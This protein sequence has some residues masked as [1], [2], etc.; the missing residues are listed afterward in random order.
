MKAAIGR[1]LTIAGVA[2]C[3]LTG[4]WDRIE[5]NQ[6]A[7]VGL[8]GSDSN[9]KTHEQSIYYQI[10]NPGSF[11]L[12]GGESS[13]S[14]VYTYKIVGQTKG[15]LGFKSADILPRKLFT[16]QYQAHIIPESYARQGLTAFLNFYERQFNRRS[17]LNLFVTDSA[18]ADVMTTYTPLER[19]PGRALR[20]LVYNAYL[21]TGRISLKSRVK[22]LAE[23]ME[24]STLS[25]MPIIT[26]ISEKPNQTT[27]RFEMIQAN[28]GNLA[29]TGAALFKQGKMI[30]KVGLRENGYYNLIKGDIE[31]FFESVTVEGKDVDLRASKLKVRK[32]LILA[33]GMPVLQVEVK[34]QLAIMSNE[35]A[36]KMTWSNVAQI[37]GSF[38]Q[39]VSAT[40]QK[41][42]KEALDKKWD[43]FGLQD[44][45]KYKHGKEWKE[46]QKRE[47]AWTKTK[48]R[49]TVKS[50]VNDVGEI[51][52]PYKGG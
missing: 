30:G 18:L 29:L 10:I 40:G 16:D 36:N 39:Q 50:T 31:T 2:L 28:P 8:V 22:D 20:S 26:L 14:P 25:V 44:Q 35:Q 4:C 13:K 9:P 52:N 27:K 17:S 48:L 19:M 34:A 1:K 41:L 12:Q 42:F 3:C 15:E 24:S 6:L 32:R 47:D 46:L 5:I 23:T 33:D 43:L 7:V 21:S 45:I 49:L 11:T 51:I 38:D 37:T